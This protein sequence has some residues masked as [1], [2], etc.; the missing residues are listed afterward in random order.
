MRS[1]IDTI[2]RGYP[3]P[4]LCMQ[5]I[6]DGAGEEKHYVVDGQQRI[7]VTAH[8]T[9]TGGDARQTLDVWGRSNCRT[10]KNASSGNH[11]IG[12]RQAVCRSC[13]A[14]SIGPSPAR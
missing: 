7:R 12:V 3:I 11:A 4:E 5:D 14:S 1:L 6:A 9:G 8:G 2:L 10:C 13:G